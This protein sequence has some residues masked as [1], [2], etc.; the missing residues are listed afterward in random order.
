MDRLRS[1]PAGSRTLPRGQGRT[2]R[3]A[4][5]RRS[6]LRARAGLSP[7]S[8]PVPHVRDQPL[9]QRFPASSDPSGLGRC[10]KVT[11][12][13]G[14]TLPRP[15]STS[16][17][18]NTVAG[19]LPLLAQRPAHPEILVSQRPSAKPPLRLPNGVRSPETGRVVAGV[20]PLRAFAF[21]GIPR[22]IPLPNACQGTTNE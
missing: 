19:R 3:P 21:A 16:Q 12:E 15:P 9:M 6:S 8:G 1:C 10:S 17:T 20:A 22:R 11:H 2:R 14:L 7:L 4:A 13:G 5:E 18:I